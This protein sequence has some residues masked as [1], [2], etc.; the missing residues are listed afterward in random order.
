MC[1]RVGNTV[2]MKLR[3]YL[4]VIV[5]DCFLNLNDSILV[6]VELVD[7]LVLPGQPHSLR[8]LGPLLGQLKVQEEIDIFH[9]VSTRGTLSCHHTLTEVMPRRAIFPIIQSDNIGVVSF[10]P[11]L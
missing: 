4:N 7:L 9:K 6:D 5:S 2:K 3:L 11:I 1:S 10:F 8:Q